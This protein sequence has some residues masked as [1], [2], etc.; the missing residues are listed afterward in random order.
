MLTKDSLVVGCDADDSITG[1]S[2]TR[3]EFQWDYE[4]GDQIY[5]IVAGRCWRYATFTI[6]YLI[7]SSYS[8]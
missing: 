6:G 3:V 1:K 8:Q 7:L 2:P 4:G 5:E